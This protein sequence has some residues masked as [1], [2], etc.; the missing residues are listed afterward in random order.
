MAAQ[1]ATAAATDAIDIRPLGPVM[2][3]EVL[4]LD[5][6][7]SLDSAVHARIWDAFNT[8]KLLCFRDQDLT[9]DSLVEFTRNWGQPLEHTMPGQLKEGVRSDVNVATNATAEG[10]PSGRHP[11]FTAMRWHTDRSWRP[12]PALATLLYGRQVPSVGAD[13]LFCNAT[14][15]YEALPAA[16]RDRLDRMK[17]IHSVEYSRRAAG[18][19]PATEYELK[20]FPPVAHPVAR[21]HP[22]TGRKALYCGSHAWKMEGL[23]EEDGRRMIDELMAH[24]TQDRFVYRHKWRRHDLLMWDNRCTYHAATPFDTAREI[25]TMFRTVVEGDVPV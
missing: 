21:T 7:R 9:V 4:G 18:G 23:P 2:G 8:Y 25:R 14:M 20:N 15:A 5:A 13:T 17:I 10:K 22:V 6:A 1:A 24:A 19:H 16:T 11:D 3:A 12:K